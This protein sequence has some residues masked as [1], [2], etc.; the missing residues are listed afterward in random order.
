MKALLIVLE[1]QLN[2]LQALRQL[3]EKENSLLSGCRVD[4]SV[5]QLVAEKKQQLLIAVEH[6]DA[7]RQQQEKAASLFAP[8]TGNSALTPLW[9]Q[10]RDMATHLKQDNQRSSLLLEQQ[11]TNLRARQKLIQQTHIAQMV[12]GADGRVQSHK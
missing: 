6:F 10:I 9:Q 3:L 8:Y 4:P 5:L 7:L 2:T 1:K 12:Y 11:M